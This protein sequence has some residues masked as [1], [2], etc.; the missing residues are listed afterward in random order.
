MQVP[1][2]PSL[3]PKGGPEPALSTMSW[4]VEPGFTLIAR[5]SLSISTL[6]VIFYLLNYPHFV[7]LV[8]ITKGEVTFC[9]P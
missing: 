1:H 7:L 5:K 8:K 3:H 4:I 6:V 2:S 9:V